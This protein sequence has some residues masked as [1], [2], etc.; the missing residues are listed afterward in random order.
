MKE[1]LKNYLNRKKMEK[2][3]YDW[4]MTEDPSR[5]GT[6]RVKIR[7]NLNNTSYDI[8]INVPKFC[9][10]EIGLNWFKNILKKNMLDITQK[11][12]DYLDKGLEV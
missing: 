12:L 7:M 6:I 4:E 2:V 5:D 8:V 11:Y 10:T 3:I 1:V 9:N